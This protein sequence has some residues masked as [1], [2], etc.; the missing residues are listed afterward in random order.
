MSV[1]VKEKIKCCNCNK[2]RV[3][4]GYGLCGACY[5]KFTSGEIH[6]PLGAT[7]VQ[8]GHCTHTP[9]SNVKPDSDVSTLC[10]HNPHRLPFWIEEQPADPNS[11]P[12][13]WWDAA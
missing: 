10:D 7:L 1:S 13:A 3:H 4:A 5:K 9:M 2:R 11:D 12:F 8:R 6:H